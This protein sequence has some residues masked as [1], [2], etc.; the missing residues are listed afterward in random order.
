MK[1]EMTSTPNQAPA[2][3]HQ[4]PT[5][6]RVPTYEV[7]S[8]KEAYL[9]RVHLPGV[10]RNEAN[11]TIDGE[12][13]TIEARRDQRQGEQWKTLHR[14]IERA[15]FKLRL[16]LNVEIATDKVSA[17]TENGVLT[18]RLPVAEEAK[19]RRISIE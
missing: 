7:E 4:E 11:I 2:T 6:F 10:G 14:E 17:S 1:N 5:R 15:G 12:T 19:P 18:V 3:T 8:E 16:Q 13:L 9:V